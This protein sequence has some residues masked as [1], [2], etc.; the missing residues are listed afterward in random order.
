MRIPNDLIFIQVVPV[1]QYFHWQI[2]V[3]IVSMRKHGVSHLMQV[4]VWYPNNRKG[5][6]DSWRQLSEKYGEVQF[7][8]YEDEGVDLALYIPQLRPHTL[9]KHFANN[10]DA[11]QGKIFFYHDS[12]IIFNYL[13]NFELLRAGDLNWVSDTT[14]YLD[15]D[16]LR[17]K[18][19]EGKIPAEEAIKILCDIGNVS[20]ETFKA[21]NGR[22]GGAQYILKEIDF[23]FWEDVERQVVEIRKAFAHQVP[24]SVN[25]R[26]FPTENAGF[27]S[28]C[29]DMWAVNMALWSRGRETEI[30]PELDFSWATDS[31]ETYLKKPIFHNAGVTNNAQGLFY[32]GAWIDKSPI[33]HKHAVKPDSASIHYVRAIEDVK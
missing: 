28:W 15:Y 20:V 14:S 18:E 22:T 17:R 8:F 16:Y 10:L 13:P 32:K 3:Q 5:E 6:L 31:G 19:D 29:A 1:D 26:Y 27:Q 9:K 11:F 2:E 24:G 23:Y 12:D 33:G 21:H 7:F 4:L 30:T 25:A